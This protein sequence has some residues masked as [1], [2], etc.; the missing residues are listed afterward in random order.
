[1]VTVTTEG[2]LMLNS[3][4]QV[5][6]YLAGIVF[7][8]SAPFGR[9]EWVRIT[10]RSTIPANVAAYSAAVVIECPPDGPTCF[11]LVLNENGLPAVIGVPKA[12]LRSPF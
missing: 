12:H 10:D 11:V 4:Q 6:D 5:I 2:T 9:G 7:P 8:A 3:E 1:M